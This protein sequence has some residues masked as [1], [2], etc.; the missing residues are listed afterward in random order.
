MEADFSG[1]VTKAGLKCTDGR[2]ITPEAFKHMDGKQV[3]LVWQHGHSTPENVLGHVLLEARPDGIYGHGHFNNTKPG[4]QAKTLVEHKDIN[5][6]SI[7]ANQLTERAKTVFHG[8][9]REVSL[10]LAGAN[11]GAVIDQI[12]VA[13]GD[14]EIETLEDEAI[15]TTGLELEHSDRPENENDEDQNDD[16]DEDENLE[17]ATVKEVYDAMSEEQQAVLHLMISEALKAASDLKQSEG[18]NDNDLANKEGPEGMGRNV[19]EQNTADNKQVSQGHALSHDDVRGI[20]QAAVRHGSLKAAV[21]EYG[22]QHGIDDIDV[23]FPDAKSVQDTPEWIKRRTEWVA[24]VMTGTRK[25]PFS[26]IKTRTASITHDEA[27]AKGYIKGNVKKE[28]FFGVMQR[29]TTPTTIYK[30]QGL[31]RDDIIDITD[32]D[33]VAWLKGEMRL[34][35]EEE[36]A[37]AILLGD[38]RDVSD[39]DKVRDPAGATDGAGI[40]SIL[41]DHELY[42]TRVD[43]NI[44]ATP[45]WNN[46]VESVL[47]ARRFYKGTGS[48]V[49]YTTEIVMTEMLLA[50]DGFGRRLYE[51]EQALA[52]A[53]RV[54]RIVAVEVM[55]DPLYA[56]LLGIVVNLSDYN[57]GTDRGGELNFFDD[58]DIDYNKYKYLMETRASGALTKVK[59]AMVITRTD[60]VNV[61]VAPQNPSF[62]ASTGVVTI[63][64]QTGVVYEDASDPGTP[65][66]PGAQA[67]LDPS[68]SIT[69]QAFPA[70][71]YYF[72]TNENDSWTFTRPA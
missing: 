34:M 10:V 27:R 69:V 14:G 39:D 46:V 28:E 52:T 51:S 31:D 43:V 56:D 23:L 53:L 3:P 54:S 71:G 44:G 64:N 42:V 18:T 24:G 36:F 26:R 9:I 15:I 19:F 61:L 21:Q 45:N 13:H 35:M 30:K 32:F 2:T 33:V 1:Y 25:T 8:V 68:E 49:F 67:A 57:V 6:L 7:Y 22:M 48:P 40:R 72:A 62:V 63:P 38:G 60:D 20:V 5:S 66:A 16:G 12:R 11:P 55:E 29:T 70:A 37:R 58:F 59:S 65:L 4:Q 41:N 47:R 17:H 50:K